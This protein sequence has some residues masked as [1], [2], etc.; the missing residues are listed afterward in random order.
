MVNKEST[1]S[2]GD[3]YFTHGQEQSIMISVN[4][5]LTVC[6]HISKTSGPNFIKF[7]VQLSLGAALQ[8]NMLCASGSVDD[9]IFAH[10][11][12]G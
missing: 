11:G 6:L 9:V 3:F 10:N 4:V 12:Q 2:V 8:Y 5:C 7:C 1:K